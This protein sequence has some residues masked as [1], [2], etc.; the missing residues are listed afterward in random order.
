M[1]SVAQVTDVAHGSLVISVHIPSESTSPYFGIHGSMK[2]TQKKN[3]QPWKAFYCL[4][5]ISF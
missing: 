3:E 1:A 2:V 4:F 5:S